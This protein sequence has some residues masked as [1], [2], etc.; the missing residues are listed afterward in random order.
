M[1]EPPEPVEPQH[2]ADVD[3][4]VLSFMVTVPEERSLTAI[5]E[6]VGPPGAN[7]ERSYPLG[8]GQHVLQLAEIFPNQVQRRQ[9]VVTWRW[10]WK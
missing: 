10:S 2:Q 1:I 6:Y 9:G 4:P 5:F 3:G 7:V 8:P